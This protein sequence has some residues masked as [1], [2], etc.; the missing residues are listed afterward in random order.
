MTSPAVFCMSITPFGPDGDVDEAGFRA[1]LS[2][3]ADGGVGVYVASQGSGEG[4][5]LSSDE[6]I[7]AYEVAVDSVG[8]RVP[9]HAA[10]IG[11]GDTAA[12]LSLGSRA[13]RAGVDAVQVLP[14]RIGAAPPRPVELER[15]CRVLLEALDCPMYLSHNLYLAGYP[16]PVKLIETLATDYPHLKG[17]NW[18]DPAVPA[19]APVV[20]ALAGRLEVRVGI[21]GHLPVVAALG[22][23]GVLCFEPNVDPALVPSVWSDFSLEQFGQ[24]LALN[25]L[26]SR[27]GNPRSIKAALRAMGLPAGGLRPPL[28]DISATEDSQLK[29][30][31]ARMGYVSDR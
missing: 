10:G 31:L 13:V 15:Y 2:R 12:T 5:L 26:L 30:G 16:L 7:R 21:V 20:E 29:A 19:L 18:S 4:H 6:K 14:P 22:G 11:L 28:L 25:D 27:S 23:H 17:L 24:L 1:H 3:L 8:G 9:V